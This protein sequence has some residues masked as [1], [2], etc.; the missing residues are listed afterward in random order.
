[1]QWEGLSGW[2]GL[3]GLSGWNVL[4]GIWGLESEWTVRDREEAAWGRQQE[5]ALGMGTGRSGRG[6]CSEQEQD[7]W[8]RNRALGMRTG[9]PEWRWGFFGQTRE[10]LFEGPFQKCA[11][12]WS[13]TTAQ[14]DG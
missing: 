4:L 6:R 12:L 5:R 2:N 14:C 3:L 7:A 9:R 11:K 8:N 10:K 13:V 1:M